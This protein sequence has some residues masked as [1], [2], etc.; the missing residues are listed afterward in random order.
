[1]TTLHQAFAADPIESRYRWPE[2]RDVQTLW[3]D[4]DP[5]GTHLVASGDYLAPS[6]HLEVADASTGAVL[7]AYPDVDQGVLVGP[8]FFSP[9]GAYVI[10]GLYWDQGDVEPPADALGAFILDARS[11]QL[12]HR[13]DLGRCGGI[14]TAVS[15]ARLL[16]RTPVLGRT[17]SS[18]ASGTTPSTGW[19][20]SWST[21]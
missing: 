17:D 21:C 7:W 8:S 6:D 10:A 18:P 5:S 2:G 15:A 3:T 11:G 14:V 20:S 1:M 4:L 19:R 13:I 9:D 12:V 16:V